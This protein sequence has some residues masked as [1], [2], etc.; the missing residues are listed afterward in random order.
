MRFG[1]G[2]LVMAQM[3]GGID[4]KALC[5]PA[6]CDVNHHPHHRGQTAG[7]PF[8]RREGHFIQKR[9]AVLTVMKQTDPAGPPLLESQLNLFQRGSIGLRTGQDG[10][11]LAHNLG[12]CIAGQ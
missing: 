3:V 5:L 7:S 8:Y 1:S 6:S 4:G 2:C 10:H 12:V 11:G 9:A